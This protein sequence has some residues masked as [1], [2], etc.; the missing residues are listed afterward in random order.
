MKALL[1]Y[2]V[3]GCAVIGLPMGS[4]IKDCPNSDIKSSDVLGM[5]AAW[6]VVFFASFTA[7]EVKKTGKCPATAQPTPAVME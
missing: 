3:I 2:W 6:P 4:M 5:I 7:G 1:T